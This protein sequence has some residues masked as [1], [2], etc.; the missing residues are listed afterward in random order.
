MGWWAGFG[1]AGVGM[2]VGLVVFTMGKPLLEGH[3]EPPAPEKLEKKIA[4]PL[5]AEWLI[6]LGGLAGVGGVWVLLQHGAAVGWLL[7]AG[8]AAV[9]GYL[10]W[11]MIRHCNSVERQRII[12][13]LVP[14][15]AAV[16]FWTLFE[17]A[18]SSMNQFAERNTNLDLPFGQ[19]MTAAQTQSFNAG[20]ILLL[21]PLFS[22]V[23]AWLGQR[24][25]DPNPVLKFGLRPDSGGRGFLRTGAR[26][27]HG[28]VGL[29]G[30]VDL[31]RPRLPA[32]H[33]G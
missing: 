1:L 22:A 15:A 2:L 31:P 13:A 6:Y 14:I 18:G 33:N 5:N 23:W 26:R 30:A 20:F 32:A 10:A 25:L 8:S 24:R 9:L 12:L 7:G 27:A 19:R 16:L 11:F 17:Q 3:G 28:G 21:A 4:G 29:P